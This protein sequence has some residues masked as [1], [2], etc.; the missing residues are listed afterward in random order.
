MLQISKLF[1]AIFL[2]ILVNCTESSMKNDLK[3]ATIDSLDVE[4]Y[5]GKWYE[6]ARFPHS[7]EEGLVGVTATYTLQENGSIKVVNQGYKE[8][9]DGKKVSR[10]ARA[11]LP[12][13]NHPGRLKVYFF[14]FFGADYFVLDLDQKNYHYALVG[15][16]SDKYLWILSRTPR[17]DEQVYSK[18]VEKA[19]SLGYDV[20]KLI[21]VWQKPE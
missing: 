16:S 19:D 12:D 6:I 4:R 13:L 21:K 7:F 15:S 11:R 8:T 17:M 20:S 5:M 9:L 3:N 14:L 1:V 2:L 18:L 10:T